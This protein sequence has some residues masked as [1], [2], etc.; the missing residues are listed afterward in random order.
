MWSR[1]NKAS[2]GA[3]LKQQLIDQ[4]QVTVGTQHRQHAVLQQVG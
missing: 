2:T 3:Q 4:R 1:L